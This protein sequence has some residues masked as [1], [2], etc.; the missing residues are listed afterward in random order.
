MGRKPEKAKNKQIKDND[1]DIHT[2]QSMKTAPS[3]ASL[4][5]DQEAEI[6]ANFAQQVL[7]NKQRQKGRG[8]MMMNGHVG[9]AHHQ[10]MPPG[11]AH[12]NLMVPHH[13]SGGI[14]AS[15][16]FGAQ[17]SKSGNRNKMMLMGGSEGLGPFGTSSQGT[18]SGNLSAQ[19]SKS[20]KDKL[21]GSR[22]PREDKLGGSRSPRDGARS[23]RDNKEPHLDGSRSP[24]DNN[25][26]NNN[27]NRSEGDK[28]KQSGRKSRISLKLNVEKGKT[29]TA[30]PYYSAGNFSPTGVNNF[31]TQGGNNNS[32]GP[33]S[34]LGGNSNQFAPV[35]SLG[36]NNQLGP[37]TSLGANRYYNQLSRIDE[38]TKTSMASQKTSATST[39]FGPALSG[40]FGK[41]LSTVTNQSQSSFT[42]GSTVMHNS[43]SHKSLSNSRGLGTS[44]K[45]SGGGKRRRQISV[46]KIVSA[47]EIDAVTGQK[48]K[49]R[50]IIKTHVPA[51]NRG[52]DNDKSKKNGNADIAVK[53]VLSGGLSAAQSGGQQS[54][55]QNSGALSGAVSNQGSNTPM[56]QVSSPM[57][58][59]RV[60]IFDKE[61]SHRMIMEE[62]VGGEGVEI[63]AD[64]DYVGDAGDGEYFEDADFEDD[65]YFEDEDAEFDH[66]DAASDDEENFECEDENLDSENLSDDDVDIDFQTD[67]VE[68]DIGIHFVDF[69]TNKEG[70]HLATDNTIDR[71]GSIDDTVDLGLNREHAPNKEGSHTAQARKSRGSSRLS[72]KNS[73]G[74][75]AGAREKKQDP[76][77]DIDAE[78]EKRQK[79]EQKEQK[80]RQLN[81]VV[82]F[83]NV[84]PMSSVENTDMMNPYGPKSITVRNRG[85]DDSDNSRETNQFGQQVSAKKK[86]QSSRQSHLALQK[87]TS[88]QSTKSGIHKSGMRYSAYSGVHRQ[89]NS[90]SN[91]GSVAFSVKDAD[92]SRFDQDVPCMVFQNVTFKIAQSHCILV[93]INLTF[94]YG[95][96]IALMGGSGSGKSTLCKL[97]SDRQQ[98]RGGVYSGLITLDGVPLP[99]VKNAASKIG[100]VRQFPECGP[101]EC[102]VSRFR[103]LDG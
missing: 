50:K 56:S 9:L 63:L 89:S 7:W 62:D 37:V 80:K 26:L 22:S 77:V 5:R 14:S 88:Q 10:M 93:N 33:S 101:D 57:S 87:K 47:E 82:Q 23:P 100:F 20:P 91:R 35:S 99:E 97:A 4:T 15:G 55:G 85:S 11:G 98:E 72:L 16:G 29:T 43:T 19:L 41:V 86:R 51:P 95:R 38:S 31:S 6:H 65:E 12:S 90:Q 58:G 34:S 92:S 2:L 61:G 44:S 79:K 36:Y 46:R 83:Q 53:N 8:G 49:V 40:Q 96:M 78:V 3:N 25:N 73:K 68:D 13:A 32:F 102:T 69:Q 17:V 76:V 94:R 74:I 27:L 21:D 1:S 54:A 48:K 103:F 71:E 64:G 66:E 59:A 28:K 67:L 24:R 52:G 81:S 45:E 70:S 39:N 60:D 42:S 30:A 84:T 18:G 75:L